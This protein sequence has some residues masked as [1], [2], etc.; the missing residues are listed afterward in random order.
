MSARKEISYKA[1]R[2]RIFRGIK[3]FSKQAI[4]RFKLYKEI[5]HEGRLFREWS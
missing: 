3:V 1:T 2:D 4:A 5:N